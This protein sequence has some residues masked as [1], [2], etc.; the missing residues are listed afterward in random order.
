MIQDLIFS[1]EVDGEYARFVSG[2]VVVSGDFGLQMRV[3][4]PK[5]NFYVLHGMG[6]DDFVESWFSGNIHDGLVSM[7]VR[8]VIPGMAV[9][10]SVSVLPEYG[11]ILMEG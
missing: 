10:V 11:K 8:G 9:K 2:T 3:N 7:P 5:W 1:K 4:S 6:E